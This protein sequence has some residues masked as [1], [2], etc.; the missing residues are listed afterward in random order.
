MKAFKLFGLTALAVCLIQ[1][2][3]AQ[4]TGS[5]NNNLKPANRGASRAK[6]KGDHTNYGTVTPKANPSI[7]TKTPKPGSPVVPK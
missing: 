3:N 6:A 7:H 5:S 4:T 1:L 2:L